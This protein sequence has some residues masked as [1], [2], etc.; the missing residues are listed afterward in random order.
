VTRPTRYSPNVSQVFHRRHLKHPQSRRR[1]EQIRRSVDFI[2][3]FTRAFGW[4]A[5]R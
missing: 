3:V 4:H 1:R 2:G 5:L